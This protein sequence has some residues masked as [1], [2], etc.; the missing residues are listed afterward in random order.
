MRNNEN[1]SWEDVQRRQQKEMENILHMCRSLSLGIEEITIPYTMMWRQDG[2]AVPV[3]KSEFVNLKKDG[4]MLKVK[5]RDCESLLYQTPAS[6][7][8]GSTG[9]RTLEEMR[10]LFYYS[11]SVNRI[12]QDCKKENEWRHR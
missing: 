9:Y 1:E 11:E 8:G 7:G 5:I 10:T 4:Q 3:P 6:Q 12:Y 2:M